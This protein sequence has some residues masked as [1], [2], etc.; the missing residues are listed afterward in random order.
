MRRAFALYAVADP[1]GAV[2][3]WD[4]ANNKAHIYAA[5]PDLVVA[6]VWVGAP[7]WLRPPQVYEACGGCDCSE[8]GGRFRGGEESPHLEGFQAATSSARS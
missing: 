1:D 5:V 3:E 7:E 4:E 6:S 2:G 8:F